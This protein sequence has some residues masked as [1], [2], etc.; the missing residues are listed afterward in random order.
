M[1][2]V[3]DLKAYVSANRDAL[4]E[5]LP[6]ESRQPFSEELDNV[7]RIT[8]PALFERPFKAVIAK[9]PPAQAELERQGLLAPA[10][11]APQPPAPAPVVTEAKPRESEAPVPPVAPAAPPPHAGDLRC[12]RHGRSSRRWGRLGAANHRGQR[13]RHGLPR[14]ADRG[15]DALC[16]GGRAVLRRAPKGHGRA[17]RTFS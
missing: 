16:R 17:P 4:A 3:D 8:N 7:L 13:S 12:G 14:G 15:R 9:Y 1:A 2:N 10:P 5:L 11:A 6:P